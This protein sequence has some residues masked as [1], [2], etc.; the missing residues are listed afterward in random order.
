MVNS[1]EQQINLLI[2]EDDKVSMLVV[3]KFANK[4]GWQTVIVENGLDAVNEFQRKPFHTI[5]MDIMMPVLDGYKATEIIR[6]IENIKGTRT[7]IIAM[8]AY[9]MEGDREKCLE[10]GMDD[11]ITKPIIVETFYYIVEKWLKKSMQNL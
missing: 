10:A 8:T 4:K 5:L 3:E 7:P 1:G 11:Y 2:A 9:A 6:N